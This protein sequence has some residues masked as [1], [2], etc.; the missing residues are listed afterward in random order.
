MTDEAKELPPTTGDLLKRIA[1][2]EEWSKAELKKLEDR[3]SAMTPAERKEVVAEIKE[4][5]TKDTGF[6][7]FRWLI[8]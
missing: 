2:H 3:L 6:D 1:A 5:D 7:L 8:D 4:A